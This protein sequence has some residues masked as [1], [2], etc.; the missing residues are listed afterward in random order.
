VPSGK[1]DVTPVLVIKHVQAV[2]VATYCQEDHVPLVVLQVK[3]LFQ[4]LVKIVIIP[5]LIV[6]GPLQVVILVT[7]GSC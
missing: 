1:L 3:F 6:L 7:L 4:G 5:V 2:L